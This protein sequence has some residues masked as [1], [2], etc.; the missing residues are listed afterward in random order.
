MVRKHKDTWEY[1]RAHVGVNLNERVDMIANGFARKEEVKLF[2]GEEKE[3]EE[4]LKGMP[5]AR[6]V[7]SSS[8]KKGKAYSYV[9]IVE[10]VVMI[11]ATWAECEKHVKGKKAKYKKSF[12]KEDEETMIAE[13]KKK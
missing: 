6:V 4:F 13:G 10:E 9:S 12:Y 3:Y 8:S 7:S 5:K 11:H 1:L 2:K